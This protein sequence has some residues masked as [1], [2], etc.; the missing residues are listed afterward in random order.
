MKPDF[1]MPHQL[2]GR[3]GWIS[4]ALL[5]ALALLALV[6]RWDL[7][8][9]HGQPELRRL[10]AQA[11]DSVF[12]VARLRAWL[13]AQPES[14]GSEQVRAWLEGWVEDQILAQAALRQGLD[15]LKGAR[16]E[17]GRIRLRYLRGLLEEQS[18]SESLSVSTLELKTWLK[19]NGALLELP[20]RRLRLEWWAGRDSLV[21]ARLARE[22]ARGRDV[23]QRLEGLRVIHGRTDYLARGE[24]EPGHAEAAFRLKPLQ[25][26]PVL[27][28][29]TGWVCYQ[30]ESQRPAGWVPDPDED[31][32]LV[33]AAMLQDLR[34]KRL[35]ARLE[36]LRQEAVWKVDLDPLL[37]VEAGVP[38]PRR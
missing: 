21:L 27:P 34:W 9:R 1:L 36:A 13:A 16:E 11:G 6:G 24:L 25:M 15:T 33:R 18:L 5:L 14:L 7:R 35:Q 37:E 19:G 22:V 31:E 8:R 12:T 30:L 4:L 23:G 20:E 32:A 17:L 28:L 38:P 2:R 10:V 3:R 26:T 29:S